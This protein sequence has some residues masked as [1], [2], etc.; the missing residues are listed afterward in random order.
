MILNVTWDEY[1]TLRIIFNATLDDRYFDCY[2][3]WHL[4]CPAKEISPSPCENA[5]LQLKA[6]LRQHKLGDSTWIHE[7]GF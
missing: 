5:N 3:S 1:W 7:K 6:L 4:N 2:Y